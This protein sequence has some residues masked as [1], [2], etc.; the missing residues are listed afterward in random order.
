M[1]IAYFLRYLGKLESKWFYLVYLPIFA[2][3]FDYCE[4]IGLI[5]MI[6][7]YPV[8][9]DGLVNIANIFSILKSSLSTLFYTA[10]LILLLFTGVKKLKSR[11]S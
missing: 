10:I 1:M 4:N 9:S 5:V 11:G 6:L 3:L 2:G 7:N 8:L